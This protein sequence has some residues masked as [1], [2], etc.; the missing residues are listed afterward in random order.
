LEIREMS[1]SAPVNA[2]I[3]PA[4]LLIASEIETARVVAVARRKRFRLLG[5]GLGLAAAALY[6]VYSEGSM[7]G[8]LFVPIFGI[9][10]GG[11]AGYIFGSGAVDKVE[12]DART[13]LV[14]AMAKRHG[15]DLDA[16]GFEPTDL[17]LCKSVNLLARGWNRAS[18]HD[19]ISGMHDGL[20]FTSWGAHCEVERQE[21]NT[22]AQ[23]ETTT[24][25]KWETVFRGR[26]YSI[27][28]KQKFLGRTYIT[29][30]GWFNLAPSGTYEIKPPDPRFIDAFAIF[31][32][33]GTE[34]HY[35]IDPLM[36]DRLVGL[37]EAN[38]GGNV[39]GVFVEHRLL[40]ALDGSPMLVDLKMSEAINNPDVLVAL[41]RKVT[42]AF[43]LI[44]QVS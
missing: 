9:V 15:L 41:D 12:T 13:R 42:S 25:T 38:G 11:F 39:R 22:N 34:G 21:T 24:T 5:A 6:L 29:R 40:L 16:D 8:L 14:G 19:Q 37:E 2:P 3:D 7:P 4:I 27:D 17:V 23:G 31:T 44:D 30:R 26:V 35:L 36:I 10:A 43:E 32:T 28:W 1:L 18:F 20:R 33:D